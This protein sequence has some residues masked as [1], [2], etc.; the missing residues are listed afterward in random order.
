[1]NAR[2]QN[3]SDSII[4]DIEARKAHRYRVRV[5]LGL[6]AFGLISLWGVIVTVV[7]VAFWLGGVQ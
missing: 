2:E 5:V 3:V 4:R 6:M 7:E 1:M